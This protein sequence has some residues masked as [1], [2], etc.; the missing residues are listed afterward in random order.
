MRRKTGPGALLT[1]LL[2]L[3]LWPAVFGKLPDSIP[4]IRRLVTQN[5]DDDK[6]LRWLNNL[7]ADYWNEN[8]DSSLIFGWM[9]NPL[10][11]GHVSPKNA[12]N[13]YFVLGMAWEN[14]G[15]KDSAYWYLF[16]AREVLSGVADRKYYFR[17]QEQIGSL[18]RIDG[19]YDQA[20]V[21]MNEALSYFREA[22]ND[23][24]V[25]SALFNIGSVYLEQNRYNMALHYYLESAAFD[26]VLHDTSAIGLHRLGIASIYERLGGLFKR[27]NP[28]QSADY[29]HL[30][31][32]YYRDALSLF[33]SASSNTGRCFSLMGIISVKIET[34]LIKSADSLL[35]ASADCR[36]FPDNRVKLGMS[37]AAARL[38]EANGDRASAMAILG[39]FGITEREVLMLP[40]YHESMLLLANLL[41]ESGR[42]DSALRVAMRTYTWAKQRSVHTLVWGALELMSASCERKG[43]Q[44]LALNY[45][46][47]ASNYKD[48]VFVEIGKEI[49]DESE[50]R[51]RNDSLNAKLASLNLEH[52]VNEERYL[53]SKLVIVIMLLVLAIAALFWIFR[54]KQMRLRQTETD[55][56]LRL[57]ES[58]RL[59]TEQSLENVQLA[60]QVK[61]QELI[62]HTLQNAD[63]TMMNRSI[64]DRLAEFQLRFQKKRDQEAFGNILQEIQRDAKQD[65]IGDFEL[66][67]RQMHGDFYEKLLKVCPD[68]SKAELQTCALLR[69]NLSSK[70]IARLLSITVASVD[71]TR[72]H[73]RKKLGLESSQSLSGHLMTL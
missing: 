53:V 28:R 16:K 29:F 44:G 17:V 56:K 10:L 40:E 18:Y 54:N 9:G 42:A 34:G 68:L 32:D 69:L 63:L 15:R 23:F 59:L 71:V 6:K 60:M 43:L 70:D 51:L 66:L 30:S 3:G 45:S 72:S 8:P 24:Q 11:T 48:S 2:V 41:L 7:S 13:H 46:R 52:R 38:Y 21:I 35:T 58:E 61:E 47:E 31:L 55:Q 57:A 36:E 37:I 26:T 67:F 14:K 33:E 62:Y 12:G 1:V 27:Y 5:I 20:L 22:R 4:I 49:F 73:I 64:R 25:M 39:T 19:K 65:P 50:L